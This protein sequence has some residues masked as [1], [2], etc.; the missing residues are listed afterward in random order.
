VNIVELKPF[1]VLIVNVPFLYKFFRFASSFGI[2]Q[3]F[4]VIYI[5]FCAK[6]I[7]VIS[8]YLSTASNILF[9]FLFRYSILFIADICV[10]CLFYF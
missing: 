8:P 2:P 1:P 7:F 6:V 10:G 3:A 4:P 9:V 5:L